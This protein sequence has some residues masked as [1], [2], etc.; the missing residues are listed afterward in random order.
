MIHWYVYTENVNRQRIEVVDLF[1][2]H[3]MSKEVPT[4]LRKCCDDKAVFSK[5]LKDVLM[6]QYW[7]RCEYE[8]TLT[9]WPPP[10]KDMF[11]DLKVSVF[12]QLSLNW[13]AFIDYVWLHREELMRKWKSKG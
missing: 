6:Y 3:Y 12:D 5:L 4:I 2:S 8:I 13:D 11:K 10:R 9:G 7:G 1:D